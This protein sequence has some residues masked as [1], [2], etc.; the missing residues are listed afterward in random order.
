M[1]LWYMQFQFSLGIHTYINFIFH[2]LKL[3]ALKLEIIEEKRRTGYG[4]KIII[5]RL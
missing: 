5:F 4:S 2:W 3:M 1:T